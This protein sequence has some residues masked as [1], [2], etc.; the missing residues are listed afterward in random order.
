MLYT[1]EKGGYTMRYWICC[2]IAVVLLFSAG[3]KEKAPDASTDTTTAV[4]TT[5]TQAP[6][7]KEGWITADSLRVRGGAGLTSEVI[8]GITFGEKV[9][10]L[11]KD[12]DWYQI[13]FGTG[14]GY[15][16]GQY[17]TFDITTLTTATTTTATATT[18]IS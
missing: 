14:I 6:L 9:E 1:I 4:T 15:V 18:T 3:C 11:A 5:K 10:I 7:P 2:L 16:S 8:G 13:R 12:G 17:L